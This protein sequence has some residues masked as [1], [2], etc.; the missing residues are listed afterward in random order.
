MQLKEERTKNEEQKSAHDQIMKNLQNRER[1]SV[2]GKEEAA[3][4]MELIKSQHTKEY[5]D[6]EAKFDE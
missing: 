1:E 2:I 3:S 5:Q 6:L 4:R